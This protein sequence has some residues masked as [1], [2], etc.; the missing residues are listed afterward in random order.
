MGNRIKPSNI[1]F[2]KVSNSFE[3]AA[4]STVKFVGDH[5]AKFLTGISLAAIG[6]NIRVR[7]GRKKDQKAFKESSVKQQKVARKHEAEMNA[8]KV[9]A[10]QA[11][12]A[13]KRVDQLEQIV[14][15][16]TEGVGSKWTNSNTQNLRNR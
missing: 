6:D 9:E 10:E 14:K 1:D 8:L 15:N 13:V 7:F 5:K 16:I 2:A 12:E 3:Q 11:Q 4:R